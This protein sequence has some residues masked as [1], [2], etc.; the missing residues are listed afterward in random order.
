MQRRGLDPQCFERMTC[1]IGIDGI[2]SKKPA[3]I[4]ISVA[5]EIMQVYDQLVGGRAR[6]KELEIIEGAG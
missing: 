3:V 2:S 4:A 6:L 5:A 1:P